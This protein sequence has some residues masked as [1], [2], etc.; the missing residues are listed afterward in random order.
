M[1]LYPRYLK[2]ALK[3]WFLGVQ[4]LAFAIFKNLKFIEFPQPMLSLKPHPAFGGVHSVFGF[5]TH[6]NTLHL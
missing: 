6:P 2:G 5:S 1:F 4:K 3:K